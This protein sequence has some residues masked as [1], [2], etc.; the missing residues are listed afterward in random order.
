MKISLKY[1][2]S[3]WVPV[4]FYLNRPVKSISVWNWQP[5]DDYIAEHS[6]DYADYE[7]GYRHLDEP[8]INAG[9]KHEPIPIKPF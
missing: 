1:E 9:G 2:A 6:D 3:E 7:L 5:I 8:R 4:W